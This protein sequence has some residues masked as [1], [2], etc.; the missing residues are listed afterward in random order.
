[1][2]KLS[3]TQIDR[4]GDR[5]RRGPLTESDLRLLDEYRRSFGEAYEA[6]VRII[7][8]QLQLEPTGRPAKSTG[9][10]IEKLRRE[11]IRLSQIQ[12]ISG[13]RVVVTNIADQE[14]VIA[15]LRTTFPGASVVDRRANP[16]YGYRAVHVV[17]SISEKLIEIQVRTS[18]Q[19]LWA[20]LSE[21]FSD[22]YD[23]NIKYGG[24]KERIR[25]FL[26]NA[27]ENV[28]TL[29]KDF[30][31]IEE[32]QTELNRIEYPNASEELQTEIA[33][34]RERAVKLRA[35]M[36]QSTER[37]TIAFHDMISELAKR[38]GQEQ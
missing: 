10:I 14:Q 35:G 22:V 33:Q 2:E 38:K 23:P 29:E 17:A 26:T 13:C 27:S 28:A 20:E 34:L 1:M 30:M 16:S 8:E 31:D 25:Q 18:L 3:K 19:H 37:L 21:K 5:I 24:G 6:T 15:S 4:L 11:S 7:R 9:A 36:S 12:D 32:V